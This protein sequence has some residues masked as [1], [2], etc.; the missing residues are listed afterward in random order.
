MALEK[1]EFLTPD[2]LAEKL[3]VNKSWVYR[4]TRQKGSDS[5]PRIRAGKY[6]RF[7]LPSVLDW[8]EQKSA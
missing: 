8:L 6:L 3:K 7:N 4:Q 5:I 1:N 2:E